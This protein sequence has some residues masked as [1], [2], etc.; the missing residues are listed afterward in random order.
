LKKIAGN[1]AGKDRPRK[2]RRS[3]FLRLAAGAALAGLLAAGSFGQAGRSP[4]LSEYDIKA[5]FLYNFTRYVQW[6]EASETETFTIAVFG[7]SEVT[8]PLRE[9]AKKRTVG[10]KPLLIRQCFELE[11]IGHP[12]ILFIA[13]SEAR[14]VAQVLKLTEGLDI[15]TVGETDGLAWSKG[16]AINFV[17]QEEA[18]KFEISAKA[19]DKTRLKIGSQLLKLAILVDGREGMDRS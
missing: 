10:S 2:G 3:P 12:Q 18:V 19:V 9:I 13:K 17:L 4:A 7:E 16:L 15:L 5:V 14:R 1:G 8:A 11:Q 6:P